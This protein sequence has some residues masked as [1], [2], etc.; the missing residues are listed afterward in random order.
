MLSSIT[1][2]LRGLAEPKRATVLQGFF[3]TGKGEYAEGDI[4]IGCTVPNVRKVAIKHKNLDLAS[5][6]KLLRSPIH[7]ERL[8]SLIILTLQM[9]HAPEIKKK[10][11][12][13]LYMKNKKYINNWDLVD[14]SADKI[15]GAYLDEKPKEILAQLA[16][17]TSIWDRRIAILATFHY[18]KN[19]KYEQTLKIARILLHDKH[20]L[21]QKAVGWMLREVG[22]RCSEK[23]EREFLDTYHA[24]MPRTMLRYAIERFPEHVRHA[25]LQ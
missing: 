17:S 25:Y 24:I 1:S 13:E 18:I 16:R 4:F 2:D 21:I 20:D 8:L 15:V 3:K 9:L 19:K 6:E 7:E 14:L 5:V 23:I 12:Y 10:K 22:K 11:I